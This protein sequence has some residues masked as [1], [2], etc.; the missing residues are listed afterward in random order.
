MDN[1]YNRRC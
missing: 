1:W